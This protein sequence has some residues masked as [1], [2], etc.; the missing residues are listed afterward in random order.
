MIL[1]RTLLIILAFFLIPFNCLVSLADGLTGAE[2]LF[3]PYTIIA[4]ESV[5]GYAGHLCDNDYHTRVTLKQNESLDLIPAENGIKGLFFDFYKPA[6]NL[7]LLF[8]DSRGETVDR[9]VLSDTDYL[10]SVEIPS[11]DHSSIASIRL[12]PLT[13]E[14]S[15]SEI[16]IYREGFS[17]PF[18]DTRSAADVLLVLNEPGDE[19]EKYGGLLAL[20]AGEHNLSVQIL[21]FTETEDLKAHQCLEALSNLGV[22]RMP[23]FGKA[24]PTDSR[25]TDAVYSTLGG[26]SVA[27]KNLVECIRV[28]RPVLVISL[29][30]SE[31][32]ERF[33]DSVITRI[34]TDAV[35][36]A[37]DPKHYPDSNAYTVPK[38]YSLSNEGTTAVDLNVPLISFNEREASDVGQQT[39]AGYTEERVFRRVL[40]SVLHFA[41]LHSAV[42]TDSRKDSLFENLGPSDFLSFVSPTPLPTPTAEPTIEPTPAPTSTAAPTVTPT[43]LPQTDYNDQNSSETDSDAASGQ[44]PG[45]R[46]IWYWIVLGIAL[47]AAFETVFIVRKQWKNALI[48]AATGIVLAMLI[49]AF[50]S[51]K[52]QEDHSAAQ[53][54][55]ASIFEETSTPLLTEE[56]TDSPT[57]SSTPICS[58]TISPTP[59]QEPVV[60]PDPEAAYYLDYDGEE[61]ASDFAGRHW[62]YKSNNLAI[63]IVRVDTTYRTPDEPLVY[64]VADIH[65]RDGSSYRSGIH[66]FEPPWKYARYEKAVLAITGDNL[67]EAEKELKGCLIRKGVFYCDYGKADTLVIERDNRTLSI[68]HPKQFTARE[69]L[70][71]GIRNSYSFGPTLIEDGI[72]PQDFESSR[73]SHPN[74]R[75]GIGM[76]EPGHWIAIVTDGRQAGYSMS[77]SLD[78]FAKLFEQYHCTVAY[79]LD[80]G[81][82]AGM[83][84]MGEA[85]NQHALSRTDM[86]RPWFDA[87]MFGYSTN[88]PSPDVATKHNGYHYE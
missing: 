77:I 55:P 41:L 68:R 56:P 52:I 44:A 48:C 17:M 25:R 69:L 27:L 87:I 24:K 86:Q 39:Y 19:L 8:L 14:V 2:E 28:L 38:Y 36:I 70:D 66:R 79:N 7:E 82:S 3:L 51:A 81:A 85:L 26:R 80:G 32:Q 62:W 53:I 72:I 33:S 83:V 65:M 13:Q 11:A 47:F 76:V 30:Y 9:K 61:F 4:P 58:P 10:M 20:L 23:V 54:A 75:C 42:G 35:D 45:S 78:Y 60:T 50:Y 63:D 74:P 64:Y 18:P 84:F 15:F 43:P 88:I 1:K 67:I 71:Y 21:Y 73:I 40:P 5:Q 37:A 46:R 22:R 59:Y 57:L 6:K 31:K 16:R 29:D 34:V 12:K 49:K